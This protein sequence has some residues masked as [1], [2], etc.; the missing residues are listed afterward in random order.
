[1]FTAQIIGQKQ[2]WKLW[3]AV[4]ENTLIRAQNPEGYWETKGHIG[5]SDIAGRVL[6]TCFCCLQLEVFYRFLPS[7]NLE[8]N[9]VIQP[10]GIEQVGNGGNHGLIIE[11]D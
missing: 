2:E 11:V 6:A 1:M 10:S 5:G 7:S 3:R 9:A 4:F 8:N